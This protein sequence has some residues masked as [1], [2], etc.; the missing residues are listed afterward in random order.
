MGIELVDPSKTYELAHPSGAKFVMRHW[1]FAM[2]EEVDRRCIQQDGK[3]GVSYDVGLERE[4]KIQNAV[5]NWSGITAPDGSE[6]PC[7]P[8]NKKKLPVGIVFWIV[9]EIDEL[10]GIRM[11]ESEKKN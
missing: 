11:P 4:I 8:E 10:S 2:Q 5:E 6:A 7:T 9:K 1:T 3:G